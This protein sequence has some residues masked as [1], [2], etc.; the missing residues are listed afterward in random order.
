MSEYTNTGLLLKELRMKK[1]LTQLELCE[2]VDPKMHIQYVSNWERGLC[3]PPKHAYVALAKV[4]RI[5]KPI[6][7]QIAYCLKQDFLI[8]INTKHRGL[9]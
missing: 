3:M 6:K 2:K 8:Q 5:T 4:L 1:G 9:I 7:T